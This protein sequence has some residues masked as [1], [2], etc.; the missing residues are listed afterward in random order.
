MLLTTDKPAGKAAE[1]LLPKHGF[2]EQVEYR[3]VSVEYLDA[4][5]VDE[6]RHP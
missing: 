5:T 1:A 2:P 3:Y 6:F 4:L